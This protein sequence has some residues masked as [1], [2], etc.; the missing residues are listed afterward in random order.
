M[1]NNGVYLIRIQGFHGNRIKRLRDLRHLLPYEQM[2]DIKK[3]LDGA[4]PLTAYSPDELYKL[5]LALNKNFDY[6]MEGRST[7]CGEVN[8]GCASI[9]IPEHWDG[10]FALDIREKEIKKRCK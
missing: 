4:R 1:F 2:P 10:L 3:I 8:M 5:L 6:I 9:V 7:G